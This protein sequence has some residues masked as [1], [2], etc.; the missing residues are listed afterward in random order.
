[1]SEHWNATMGEAL[2][3][4]RAGQLAQATTLLQRGLAGAAGGPQPAAAGVE[5]LAGRGPARPS[6][7]L[8][9]LSGARPSA[10]SDAQAPARAGSRGESHRRRHTET[11]G[12]RSYD[13]YVPG[14][15]RGDPVPL[16]VMLHGGT[17]NAIDFAAGTRMNELAERN[18]FLV[19]YPEQSRAANRGGYWNWFSPT[20]QRTGFGEPAII[21]GITRQ[22]MGDLAV[23]SAR[24]YIAGLSAG[25]AM[26]AVMAATYPDLYAAVGVH[27]GVGYRAA[28]DAG[29]AFAAMRTGGTPPATGTVPLIV[30][31]GDEDAIVAPINAEKLIGCRLA[32]GDITSQDG[33]LTVRA[34]GGRPYT[35]TTYYSFDAVAVAESVIVHGGGHAWYGGNPAGSYT[36]PEGP[37][38]SAE[39]I[40]FFL[41]HEASSHRS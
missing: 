29:S 15:Y 10:D 19:A 24:V 5:D 32:A 22:V 20:H 33:P 27:S 23:D 38:A 35:R 9:E 37:N 6:L 30:I 7:A 4:T 3:L 26:A 25:G 2:R 34:D 39:M 8:A 41:L 18:T 16:V 36:D 1:M 28:H 17:Q 40:R 14:G 12:T 21:A 13:L 11:A 31:H